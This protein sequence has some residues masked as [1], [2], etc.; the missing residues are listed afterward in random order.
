[1]CPTVRCRQ[2][3]PATLLTV[4]LQH[5]RQRAPRLFRGLQAI[6]GFQLI[7]RLLNPTAC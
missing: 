5:L 6:P 3:Q 7:P 4:G 1:M 2:V